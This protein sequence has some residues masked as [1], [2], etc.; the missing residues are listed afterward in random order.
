MVYKDTNFIIGTYIHRYRYTQMHAHRDTYM[1]MH[2]H[3]YTHTQIQIPFLHFALFGSF[4]IHAKD[5]NFIFR[6]PPTYTDTDTHTHTHT[7]THMYR[8]T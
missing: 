6:T 1:P 2:T 4:G 3:T 7:H 5:T 8:H